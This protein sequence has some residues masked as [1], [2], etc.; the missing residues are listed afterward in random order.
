MSRWCDSCSKI[1]VLTTYTITF[2][3]NSSIEYARPATQS[4]VEG[5]VAYEYETGDVLYDNTKETSC[6]FGQTKCYKYT[7]TAT[8]GNYPSTLSLDYVTKQTYV[9]K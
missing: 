2:E 4:C 1:V 7:L 6:G 5:I 9:T 8:V 3:I